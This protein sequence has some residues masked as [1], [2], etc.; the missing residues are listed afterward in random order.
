LEGGIC[1]KT[2]VVI[3]GVNH[4]YQL[5]S[6]ACQPAAYRAFFDLVK[7]DGIGIEIERAPE[8]LVRGDYYE[9]TYEQQNIVVP[10]AVERGIQL[11]PFDWMGDAEDSSLAWGIV[12]IE[13]PPLIRQPHLYNDFTHFPVV[14]E[15]FFYSEREDIK[16]RIDEWLTQK[17]KGQADFPRR[18]FLYRTFMQAMRIKQIAKQ[19]VGKTLL[20]V[21]GHMHKADIEE[22]LSTEAHIEIVQPSTYDLPSA[23]AIAKHQHPEDLC[24]IAAFNLMGVQQYHPVERTWVTE[25][26]AQLQ[27]LQPGYEVDVYRLLLNEEGLMGGVL[28]AVY[29]ELYHR[30]QGDER[31]TYTGLVDETRLDSYFHPFAALPIKAYLKLMMAKQYIVI[32]DMERAEALRQELLAEFTLSPLQ[33]MQFEG[34]YARFILGSERNS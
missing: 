6:K 22:M 14:E 13:N 23:A 7:P 21:V 8:H 24:A 18:L 16:A 32:K 31:F 19:Y 26:L 15:D 12:D 17:H 34:Y 30:L 25:V 10:Y 3:F 33:T 5:V 2:K 29:Q 28:I 1:L 9:F 11:H 27:E 20:I 4:A